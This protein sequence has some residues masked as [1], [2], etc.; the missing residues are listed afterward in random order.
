MR[1]HVGIIAVE[2]RLGTVDG[3]LLGLIDML[4]AAVVTP[5]RIALGIFIGEN[6]VLHRH[7]PRAGIVL[8]RYQF[9]MF[10]L[11]ADLLPYRLGQ[12]SIKGFQCEG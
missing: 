5:S 9:H 4:A 6:G 7:H 10:L 2:Q 3:Q 8:G 12:C 11:A 1:L